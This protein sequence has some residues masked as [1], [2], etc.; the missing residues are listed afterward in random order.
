MLTLHA[1]RMLAG[2]L[3]LFGCWGA[4]P[5]RAQTPAEKLSPGADAIRRVYESFAARA[6]TVDDYT[7]IINACE[8]ALNTGTGL[9]ATDTAYAYRLMAWAYDHRG[10]RHSAAGKDDLAVTDFDAAL[11]LDTERWQS[12]HNRG[13]SL[14]MLGKYSEALEDFTRAIELNPKHANAYYNRAELYYER[15]AYADAVADY[16]EAIRLSS[17]PDSELYNG[18]GHSFYRLGDYEAAIA[19]YTEAIRIDAT[20]A[21]AYTNR[22]D[23]YADTGRYD[24]ASLDYRAAMR[25]DKKLGRAYQSAAWLMA[26]CPEEHYR[27]KDKAIQAARKAIE[28]DGQDDPRYLDTLAAALASAG[29]YTEAEAVILQAL[30][31]APE[32]L[33]EV[34]AQRLELYQASQPYR[35][36]QP[37]AKPGADSARAPRGSVE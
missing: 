17:A 4:L 7:Q 32:E 12:Y 5:A 14:A 28:L 27:D 26:T 15:G 16:D 37:Q 18:R 2:A 19:D 6:K 10:A 24:K 22:G 20:N 11:T 9:N 23:A 29:Q 30:D 36:P 25:I 21:A 31:K 35:D 1:R 13:V 33:A 34:Y 8:Q 3:L